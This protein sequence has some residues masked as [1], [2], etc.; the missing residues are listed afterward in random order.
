MNILEVEE[1]GELFL[2]SVQS[3]KTTRKRVSVGD[4][5]TNMT[6]PG[7]AGSAL[8]VGYIRSPIYIQDDSLLNI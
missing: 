2:P 5:T 4:I 6:R 3:N 8:M 7:G 1:R